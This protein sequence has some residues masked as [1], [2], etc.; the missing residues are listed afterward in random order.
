MTNSVD[1]DEMAHYDPSHLD[2]CC[3][4]KP[5]ITACGSKRANLLL[6]FVGHPF[7][8]ITD[9]SKVVGSSIAVLLC[10]FM[11]SYAVFV[12]PLFVPQ[13]SSGRLCFV[14]VTLFGYGHC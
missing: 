4:Q 7:Q 10:A 12:L 1:P 11:V 3:L 8:F 14:A 5:I 9:R 2:L 6:A 13:L